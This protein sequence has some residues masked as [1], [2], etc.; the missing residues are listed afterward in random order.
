M[1]QGFSS[2]STKLK[3][4]LGFLVVIAMLSVYLVV[5][6]LTGAI[7]NS[8]ANIGTATGQ[9]SNTPKNGIVSVVSN[10]SDHDGLSDLDEQ[11][12]DTDPYKADTDGDGYLDGEEVL[13]GTD[14]T[15]ADP[16]LDTQ[17][18]KDSKNLTTAYLNNFIGGYMAGNLTAE[19]D[20]ETYLNNLDLLSSSVLAG[21]MSKNSNA[22]TTV[23]L[24]LDSSPEETKEY[25]TRVRDLLNFVPPQ[26]KYL[27]NE[28]T[29]NGTFLVIAMRF[30]KI[31]SKFNGLIVPQ[32]FGEW[33]HDMSL[34][35][36]K[37]AFFYRSMAN[38]DKDPILAMAEL[39]LF[40]SIYADLLDGAN[41][42]NIILEKNNFTI[43]VY[44]YS[45]MP[46]P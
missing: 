28:T 40:P 39:E 27:S 45:R 41:D 9:T 24:T 21:L 4:V 2:M 10:D 37:S 38:I 18:L 34:T 5:S 7:T 25:L 1:Q 19:T 14:P 12:Y 30:E 3:L 42:L 16:K 44:L 36:A 22:S 8:Q 20:P 46:K 6:S 17:Q 33:H 43:G 31:L 13:A 32:Q 15:I 23:L 35:L 26:D 29:S 11:D